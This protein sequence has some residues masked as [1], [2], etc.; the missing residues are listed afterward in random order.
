MRRALL[1][2]PTSPQHH[3]QT[4]TDAG[5][6]DHMRIIGG[7]RNMNPVP[8]SLGYSSFG[9][10]NPDCYPPPS[11]SG[12]LTPWISEVLRTV[13]DTLRAGF[14]LSLFRFGSPIISGLSVGRPRRASPHLPKVIPV[15]VH[16]QDQ[17]ESV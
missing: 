4:A 6:A 11:V 14:T 5:C 15:N 16:W 12:L 9:P 10:E 1:H 13:A 7:S 8:F 3:L 17:F 2:A